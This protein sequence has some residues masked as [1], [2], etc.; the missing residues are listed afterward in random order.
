MLLGDGAARLRNAW[1]GVT[2]DA[3]V[4][5][6]LDGVCYNDAMGHLVL[7]GTRFVGRVWETRPITSGATCLGGAHTAFRRNGGDDR[8]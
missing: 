5:A 3:P 1:P 7:S 8:L 6:I 4:A 2:A